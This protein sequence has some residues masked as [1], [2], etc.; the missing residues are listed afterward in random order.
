MISFSIEDDMR[1][2]KVMKIIIY[3]FLVNMIL[4]V[5]AAQER[6]FNGSTIDRLCPDDLPAVQCFVNPCDYAIC[7]AYPDATCE[8]NYC[9]GC[10]AEFYVGLVKVYCLKQIKLGSCPKLQITTL[11]NITTSDRVA[12]SKRRC[13]IDCDHDGDCDGTQKCCNSNDCDMKCTPP[14][15]DLGKRLMLSF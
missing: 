8:P 1:K 12:A 11:E 10:Y 14:N 6:M 4:S 3:W 15:L 2:I 5:V 9:G 13:V 7:E